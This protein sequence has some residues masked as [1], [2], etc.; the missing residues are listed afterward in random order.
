MLL[1]SYSSVILLMYSYIY[2][3]Y[4]YIAFDFWGFSFRT[5]R[6]KHR[7][8]GANVRSRSG[9]HLEPLNS[10]RSSRSEPTQPSKLSSVTSFHHNQRLNVA[11]APSSASSSSS[12]FVPTLPPRRSE[13]EGT[14][15]SNSYDTGAVMDIIRATRK[16]TRPNFREFFGK[17][18]NAAVDTGGGDDGGK[19][20]N[21]NKVSEVDRRI[22][23]V[24]RMQDIYVKEGHHERHLQQQVHEQ[25]SGESSNGV[26]HQQQKQSIESRNLPKLKIDTPEPPPKTPTI[27]DFDLTDNEFS[28]ISKYFSSAQDDGH[29]EGMSNINVKEGKRLRAKGAPR[30][31]PTPLEEMDEDKGNVYSLNPSRIGTGTSATHSELRLDSADEMLQWAQQLDLKD[32]EMV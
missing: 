25:Y 21:I 5:S 28:L 32:L 14:F 2:I 12:T 29:D 9:K 16:V 15:T 20:V 23:G 30:V 3:Q 27:E 8:G 18:G 26:I 17:N 22:D 24:K 6:N 13:Q 7:R 19:N 4:I 31:S 10:V 1:L 11:A